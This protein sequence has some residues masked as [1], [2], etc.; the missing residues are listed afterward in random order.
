MNTSLYATDSLLRSRI[1]L[2]LQVRCWPSM[3][4]SFGDMLLTHGVEPPLR[5]V[6]GVPR[7][8]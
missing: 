6:A 1:L 7:Y 3:A 4:S 2:R 5:P 8:R